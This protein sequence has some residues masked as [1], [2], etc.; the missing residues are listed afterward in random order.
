MHKLKEEL[1]F[2]E[3]LTSL[4]P[5]LKAQGLSIAQ[6]LSYAPKEIKLLMAKI[7]LDP[8]APLVNAVKRVKNALADVAKAAKEKPQPRWILECRRA[9]GRPMQPFINDDGLWWDS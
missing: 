8:S 4:E 2:E 3:R 7:G 6:L 9:F 5:A 1:W